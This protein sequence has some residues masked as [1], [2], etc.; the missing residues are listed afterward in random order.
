MNQVILKGRK[1]RISSAHE[2]WVD[3]LPS[4]LWAMRT[5]P[6]TASRESPF[7][8]AFGTKVVLPPEMMFSTL[9]TSNYEQGDSEKGLRANLDLLE[10]RRAKAHLHTLAYKKA[11]VR[12]ERMSHH[13]RMA[14]PPVAGLSFASTI[15]SS[16]ISLIA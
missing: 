9:H 6:K 13:M 8:L 14:I 10:E 11:I 16:I 3:E 4:I 12:D 1:R 7:S 15:H 2:S 5:T